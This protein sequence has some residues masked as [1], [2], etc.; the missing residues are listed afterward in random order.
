MGNRVLR[1]FGFLTL[2]A[3][4]TAAA[5]AQRTPP[6]NPSWIDGIVPGT[7]T[8]Y[9]G[10][11]THKRLKFCDYVATGQVIGG[12]PQYPAPYTIFLDPLP[13]NDYGLSLSYYDIW[14]WTT[15]GVPRCSG[16]DDSWWIPASCAPYMKSMKLSGAVDWWGAGGEYN[17]AWMQFSAISTPEPT[18]IVLLGSGLVGIG[19][20]LARRRRSA[21][22][23]PDEKGSPGVG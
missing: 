8:W 9:W 2:L 22:K 5:G 4:S 17:R 11:A 3:V 15:P 14:G 21:A 6:S 18:S 12:T 13:Y 16:A 19:A 7:L 20:S 10:C 1:V 23:R